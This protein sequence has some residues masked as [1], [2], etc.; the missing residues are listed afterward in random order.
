MPQ[1]FDF[2]HRF[3][4]NIMITVVGILPFFFFLLLTSSLPAVL[5][6]PRNGWIKSKLYC[7][8]SE[9]FSSAARD[10]VVLSIACHISRSESP[11]RQTDIGL[12][13]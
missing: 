9:N 5:R 8:V 11:R 1:R 10:I 3:N 13:K 4:Y 6:K 12:Y 2:P 7:E